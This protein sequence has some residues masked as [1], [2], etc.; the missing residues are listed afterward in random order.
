MLRG[1]IRRTRSVVPISESQA[2]YFMSSAGFVLDEGLYAGQSIHM[3][4]TPTL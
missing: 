4:S 2:E 3:V 1:R